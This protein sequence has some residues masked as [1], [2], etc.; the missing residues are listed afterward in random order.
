MPIVYAYS[1]YGPMAEM[2]RWKPRKVFS[3]VHAD[4]SDRP[5][6]LYVVKF[7]QGQAGAAALVSEV[8][9][10]SLFRLA[11]LPTLEP[12]IV[13]VTESYAAS[14]RRKSEI[15]YAV[16]A[17]EHYGTVHRSDVEDG[18]PLG[19]DDLA[20]PIQILW[21]WVLDTW[22]NNIDREKNGNILLSV[23][24]SG[25]FEVIAADQ[26]DCF[27]GA[28]TFCSPDFSNLMMGKGHAPSIPFWTEV[29]FKNGKSSAI[30]A[31]IERVRRC[32]SY[33]PQV[34]GYVPISWWQVS[35][36]EP[37]SVEQAL[38]SRAGRLEDILKPSQW[39]LPDGDN[40]IFL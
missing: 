25:K 36:I 18:P 22:V 24:G 12:V 29:I 5:G 30:R 27:C 3:T 15:P 23:T 17:G 28:A 40:A 4:H 38:I 13:R 21:L 19:Y 31:A 32:L 10:T 26:S 33:I 16:V 7:M 20:D 6:D 9:C 37:K 35:R 34:I 14:C 2:T 8:V 1:D 39:E 11:G